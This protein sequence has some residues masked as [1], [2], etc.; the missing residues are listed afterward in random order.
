MVVC[1]WGAVGG[2]CSGGGWGQNQI[3]RWVGLVDASTSGPFP[4]CRAENV[5]TNNS[6]SLWNS[7][8]HVVVMVSGLDDDDGILI[9]ELTLHKLEM[10]AKIRRPLKGGWTILC[11]H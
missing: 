3:K 10:S 5:F 4:L 2:I 7:L 9:L 6:N 8:G 1:V 11:T